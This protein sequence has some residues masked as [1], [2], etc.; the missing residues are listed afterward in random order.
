MPELVTLDCSLTQV[1][2]VSNTQPYHSYKLDGLG[3]CVRS[4]LIIDKTMLGQASLHCFSKTKDCKVVMPENWVSKLNSRTGLG[5]YVGSSHPKTLSEMTKPTCKTMETFGR[6]WEKN[7][8]FAVKKDV[9]C[10][11]VD[12]IFFNIKNWLVIARV[13]SRGV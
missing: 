2:Q 1:L 9:W 13:P 11:I 7:L 3:I 6:S 12:I 8:N 4:S 5:L 10:S